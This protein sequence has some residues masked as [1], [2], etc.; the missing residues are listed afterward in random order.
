MVTVGSAVQTSG[1]TLDSESGNRY[2][3]NRLTL[4]RKRT[5]DGR[6][7]KWVVRIR[8]RGQI[9]TLTLTEG[10]K[11]SMEIALRARR[12]I[13]AKRWNEIKIAAGMRSACAVAMSVLKK[14]YFEA[15]VEANTVTRNQNWKALQQL[16]NTA[17]PGVASFDAK[18]VQIINADLAIQWFVAAKARVDAETDQTKQATLKRSANS[19][20]AQAAS[21]FTVR[22]LASYKLAGIHHEGMDKFLAS[23]EVYQFVRIPKREYLPP[24][25]IIIKE[26]MDSW[27]TLSDRDLFL[28]IGHELAFGLRAGEVVQAKWGWWAHREGYPVLEGVGD[29]KN[30]T[31]HINVR[32]LDPWFSIMRDRIISKGW[33]GKEDEFVIGGSST[34]RNDLVY[35]A[36]SQWIRAHGWNTQKTNHALRAYSGSQVAMRYSIYEAQTW[37]RHAS[38]TVTE[39]HYSYFIKAFRPA[40]V[41]T[42]AVRWASEQ[43]AFQPVILPN[44]APA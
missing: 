28:A 13:H 12:E 14:A 23:G 8:F 16:L 29:F 39:Q 42:M 1:T 11:E 17:N 5:K 32:A 26:T 6:W 10:A 15:P 18:T 4:R 3:R 25:E 30:G 22:S 27:S 21:V 9:H 34:Q 24:D 41:T 31:G 7:G 33:R 36:A 20:F 37:L 38:V 44:A 2:T 43:R 40:D 35:R 19:R